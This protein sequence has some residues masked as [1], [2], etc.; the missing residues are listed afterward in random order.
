M[1]RY[2]NL[3]IYIKLSDIYYLPYTRYSHNIDSSNINTFH[4]HINPIYNSI[5][6]RIIKYVRFNNYRL[7]WKFL[8]HLI[9]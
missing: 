2:A 1:L 3:Y 4:I 5:S 7:R 6:S 8:L 9:R